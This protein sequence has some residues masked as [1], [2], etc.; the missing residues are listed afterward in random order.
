[1]SNVLRECISERECA[2]AKVQ[3]NVKME[4]G[5]VRVPRCMSCSPFPVTNLV[6]S[7]VRPSV[8]LLV[9]FALGIK[10][11]I[12]KKLGLFSHFSK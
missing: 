10:V 12:S 6:L 3:C 1:M 4:V 11:N 8:K 9:S 7:F 5:L 2:H